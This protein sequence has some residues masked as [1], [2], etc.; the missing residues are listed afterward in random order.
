MKIIQNKKQITYFIATS[1]FM[2]LL[3]APLTTAADAVRANYIIQATGG[4]LNPSFITWK[5]RVTYGTVYTNRNYS[6]DGTI[7]E[8]RTICSGTGWNNCHVTLSIEPPEDPPNPIYDLQYVS[9]QLDD[10]WEYA[11]TEIFNSVFTGSEDFNT[12]YD[13]ITVYQHIDWSADSSDYD[14]DIE[15]TIIPDL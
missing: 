11:I 15:M 2:M 9:S 5:D 10:M 6:Q 12:I 7:V 14:Y 1:L 4:Q 13:E 3:T 8:Y